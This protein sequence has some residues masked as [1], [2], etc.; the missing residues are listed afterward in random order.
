MLQYAA[1]IAPTEDPA[2]VEVWFH[3][4]G[5][6][7]ATGFLAGTATSVDDARMMLDNGNQVW[8]V[9]VQESDVPIERDED[10]DKQVDASE[11]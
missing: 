9:D 8:C 5:D 2:E 1:T 3:R 6:D 4:P 11:G 7:P 10:G